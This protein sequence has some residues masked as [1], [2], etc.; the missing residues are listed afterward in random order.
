MIRSPDA[1][2]GFR[3]GSPTA[4]SPQLV[5]AVAASLAFGALSVCLITAMSIQVT[6]AMPHPL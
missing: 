4:A 1:A 2:A 5:R 3:G 6:M